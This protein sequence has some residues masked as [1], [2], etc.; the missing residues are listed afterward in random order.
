MLRKEGELA[1]GREGQRPL[2]AK[3]GG[4]ELKL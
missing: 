1:E 4:P 2:R 3:I